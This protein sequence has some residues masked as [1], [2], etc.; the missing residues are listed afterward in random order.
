M[1][2]TLS[3]PAYLGFIVITIVVLS[4]IYAVIIKLYEEIES[5]F[6]NNV[7]VNLKRESNI[8]VIDHS[9]YLKESLVELKQEKI[10]FFSMFFHF[11]FSTGIANLLLEDSTERKKIILA[12][13][14]LQFEKEGII[15]KLF[16]RYISKNYNCDLVEN[17]SFCYTVNDFK[18]Y[19][20][21]IRD[22]NEDTL[23]YYERL[24]FN[25]D[26]IIIEKD[27][28]IPIIVEFI[29]YCVKNKPTAI[30]VIIKDLYSNGYDVWRVF[31]DGQAIDLGHVQKN[32]DLLY[33]SFIEN[34]VIE[35]F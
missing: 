20:F 17:Y 14:T 30:F 3:I 35:N 34:Y 5:K 25:F 15:E 19:L 6:K 12:L 11:S 7:K 28:L 13:I 8:N 16:K 32:E 31:N 29:V 10:N 1:K 21:L 2:D 9:K 33:L 23:S 24:V 26:D 18:F 4:I 27:I 22:Y